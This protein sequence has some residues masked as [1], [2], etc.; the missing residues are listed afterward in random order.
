VIGD[1]GRS[2]FG[3]NAPAKGATFVHNNCNPA[4]AP[5]GDLYIPITGKP[6]RVLRVY[7]TDWPKE[8]PH[9]GYGERFLPRK[10]LEELMLEYAKEYIGEVKKKDA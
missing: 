4:V 7:R 8:Q 1:F 2:S 5:N 9:Y 10:K 3:K 6:Q